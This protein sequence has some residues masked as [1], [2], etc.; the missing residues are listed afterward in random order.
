MVRFFPAFN[1][2]NTRKCFVVLLACSWFAGFVVGPIVALSADRSFF[3][4]MRMM[5]EHPVSIV[6]LLVSVYLPLLLT[7]FAVYISCD[8]LLIPIAFAKS[9]SFSLLYCGA[10]V[11]FGSGGWLLAILLFGSDFLTLGLLLWLWFRI[12][13][14]K[15]PVLNLFISILL[16]FTAVGFLD[17]FFISPFILNLFL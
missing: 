14:G 7:A 10:S 12:I 11:S 2:A 5:P 17:Y 1:F 8:W 9:L 6:G 4:L 3:S 16:V 13:P 15:G